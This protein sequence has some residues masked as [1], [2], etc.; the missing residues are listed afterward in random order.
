MDEPDL[1][2]KTGYLPAA[3]AEGP[4]T[5]PAGLPG[6]TSTK[7]R[8]AP[9][10]I[11]PPIPATARRAVGTVPPPLP[12][13]PAAAGRAS[14]VI[15]VQPS[16]I[17]LPGPDVDVDLDDDSPTPLPPPAPEEPSEPFAL[18]APPMRPAAWLQTMPAPLPRDDEG[19]PT[20]Y[21]ERPV[22]QTRSFERA[23]HGRA[24]VY[25]AGAALIGLLLGA[26][27]YFALRD[28]GG[29]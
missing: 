16:D 27:L 19:V 6:G 9:P 18:A 26:T 17:G 29:A 11:P 22:P 13:E 7:V 12:E 15:R 25:A 28:H 20:T 8:A 23:T 2:V 14:A 24:H 1:T 4:P 21:F 10:P 3:P 5:P